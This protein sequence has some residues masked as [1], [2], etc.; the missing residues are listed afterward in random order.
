MENNEDFDAGKAVMRF[1][2]KDINRLANHY[3][4][5]HPQATGAALLAI[6]RD[7]YIRAYGPETAAMMFYRVADDLAVLVPK[8]H[9]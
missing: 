8:N 3:Y 5:K 1:A 4:D 7:M 9:I 2:M 6:T